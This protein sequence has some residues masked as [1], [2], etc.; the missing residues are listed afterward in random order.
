LTDSYASYVVDITPE[1]CARMNYLSA[2]IT[3]EYL[4]TII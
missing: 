2:F 3:H 4:R 1:H